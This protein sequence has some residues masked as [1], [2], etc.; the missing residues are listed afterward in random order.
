MMSSSKIVR[1]TNE[2]IR[3]MK[4]RTDWNKVQAA[5]DT[6]IEQWKRE[7]GIDD[8]DFGPARLVVPA[9]DVHALRS[10]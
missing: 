9:T 4:G 10:T 3:E 1:L 6:E 2:K 5:T 8:A 7:D